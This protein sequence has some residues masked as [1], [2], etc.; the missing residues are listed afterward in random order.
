MRTE[1]L[2]APQAALALTTNSVNGREQVEG[3]S[4]CFRVGTDQGNEQAPS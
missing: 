3:D 2:H 4:F 1:L